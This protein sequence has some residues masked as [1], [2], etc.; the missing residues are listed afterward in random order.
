MALTRKRL[1]NQATKKS[2]TQNKS[3]RPSPSESAGL[4]GEGVIK[5]GNNGQNWVI[6]KA[7]NG[8]QRWVPLAN[9]PDIGGIIPLTVDYLAK[10][11]G[12]Q[13]IIYETEYVGR[14]PTRAEFQGSTTFTP[15]GDA[16]VGGNKLLA[17]WLRKQK[18]TIPDRVVFSVIGMG[19]DNLPLQVDSINKKLVSS[20]IMNM[21]AW[22]KV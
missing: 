22:V 3:S 18:P 13:V 15:S 14:Y 20:N 17:G 21:Q 7:S 12:K 19:A 4:F 16:K 11:I 9:G 2:R 8:I 6:K 5:R 10:H 1:V